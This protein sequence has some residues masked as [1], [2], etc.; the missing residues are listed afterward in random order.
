MKALTDVDAH[1]HLPNS[2]SEVDMNSF[3]GMV[4]VVC[5]ECVVEPIEKEQRVRHRAIQAALPVE[6]VVNDCGACVQV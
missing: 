3:V 4:K 6:D 1:T 2:V 5:T